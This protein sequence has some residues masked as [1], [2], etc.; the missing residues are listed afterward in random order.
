MPNVRT[1][2]AMEAHEALGK[3]DIPGV[4]VEEETPAED[5]RVSRV[6]IAGEEGARRLGK[7]L[8]R[9]VTVESQRLREHDPEHAQRV[10]EVVSTELAGFLKPGDDPVLVVGLGNW[11]ATPDALGPKVIDRVL[12]TRHLK[13]T[14][15]PEVRAGLRTVSAVAPGVL[16]LTGIESLEMV[17]GLSRQVEPR[18]VIA[19][20]ALAAAH[21]ERIGATIQISDT[22][23]HPGSGVGNRR[24][25]LT[26]ETLGRRVIAIGVPTVVHAMTVAKQALKTLAERLGDDVSWRDIER[27][28]GGDYDD[29]RFEEV[30]GPALGALVVTPKEIDIMIHDLTRI[31]AGA[32]NTALHPDIDL[33]EFALF[34]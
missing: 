13:E 17:E 1:D 10:G 25:G 6:E 11:N 21:V 18:L 3:V 22:G 19:I 16:G 30:L 34:S 29:A 32:I 15:E 12:V 5:I 31:M 20:D 26:F 24:G 9:Y 2:L 23:I 8:G 7:P 27:S 4:R 28:L 14:L 33:G